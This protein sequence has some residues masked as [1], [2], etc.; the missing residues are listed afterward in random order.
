MTSTTRITT[1]K[2]NS[3]ITAAKPVEAANELISP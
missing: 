3:K 2:I 1:T